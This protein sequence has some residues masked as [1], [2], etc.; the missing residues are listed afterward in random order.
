MFQL[1][2]AN[3]RHTQGLFEKKKLLKSTIKDPKKLYFENLFHIDSFSF[4]EI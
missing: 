4:K 3:K 2:S 1:V